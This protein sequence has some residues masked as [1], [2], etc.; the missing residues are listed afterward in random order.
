MLRSVFPQQRE[1]PGAPVSTGVACSR[2]TPPAPPTHAS[3]PPIVHVPRDA[4]TVVNLGALLEPTRDA[5]GVRRGPLLPRA[6]ALPPLRPRVPTLVFHGAP[7][8]K[9]TMLPPVPRPTPTRAIPPPP[10]TPRASVHDAI[11]TLI[12]SELARRDDAIELAAD[13]LVDDDRST[14]LVEAN[15]ARSE[16]PPARDSSDALASFVPRWRAYATHATQAKRGAVVIAALALLAVGAATHVALMNAI[17]DAL[18]ASAAPAP[19]PAPAPALALTPALAPTPALCRSIGSPRALARRAL[20][21]GGIDTSVAGDRVAIGFATGAREGRA[22][23]IDPST[24]AIVASAKTLGAGPVRRVVPLLPTGDVVDAALD[25]DASTRTAFD[26]ESGALSLSPA[27]VWRGAGPFATYGRVEGLRAAPLSSLRGFAMAFRRN[28]A[29]WLGAASGESARRPYAPLVRV[30]AAGARVGVP[31]VTVSGDTVVVAWAERAT[32]GEPWSVKW[33]RWKPGLA[34]EATRTLV[35]PPDGLGDHAMSPSIAAL[36]EG[37]LLLAWTEGPTA[38]HQVRAMAIDESDALVG[39]P[40]SLSPAGVNAGQG[41]IAI[42]SDGRGVV[43]FFAE[44]RGEIEVQGA[45]LTCERAT[46]AR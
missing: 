32:T 43:A 33:R 7:P 31:S 28:S 13:D 40:L 5:N 18:S 4:N 12:A 44:R 30:S 39:A 46:V 2:A 14:P 10:P 1:F 3:G 19:A 34:P 26:A 41:Q 11:E 35:M 17:G 42:T 36:G 27:R 24:L 8:P 22:L 45:A 20:V 9:R 15:I 37:R 29:I 16:R 23:E 21:A 38:A 6:N 25:V